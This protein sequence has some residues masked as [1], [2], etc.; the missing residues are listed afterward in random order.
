MTINGPITLIVGLA[1]STDS[2]RAREYD[3]CLDRNVNNP[4]IDRVIIVEEECGNRSLGTRISC[5]KVSVVKLVRRSFYSD[6]VEIANRQDG[7]VVIAN[8]DVY[9]DWSVGK[10]RSIPN[11]AL[12]AITRTDLFNTLGSSDAWAFRP[13]MDVKGCEWSL[14]RMGCEISFCEQV[15]KQLDWEIWNPC[16][17]VRLVHLH[18]SGH[19]STEHDMCV[20]FG[21]ATDP[22]PVWFDRST[23]IFSV[24][25]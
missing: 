25:L 20:K 21:V 8:A 7:V 10:L 1:Q 17:E 12:Y 9:F 6:Y 11:K 3:A 14:G 24:R 4:N 16:Y 13:R 22:K 18:Y 19:Y 5:P 2:R 23:G 15:K